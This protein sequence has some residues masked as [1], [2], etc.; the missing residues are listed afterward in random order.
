MLRMIIII[1]ALLAG[2]LLGPEISANKG[3]VLVSVDGYTSYETTIINAIFIALVIYFILIASEWIL[4]K[5][6]SMS[7]IS[8]GWF[9]LRKTKKAQK[10][11]FLGMVALCEGE[12]KQAQK[13]LAKSAA[14]SEAPALNYIAA[15]KAAHLQKEYSLRDDYLQR[16]SDSQKECNLAAGLTWVKLQ[17]DANQYENALARLQDV[18]INYPKN[19]HVARLYLDIYPTL[20]QW[21]KYLT[22]LQ[23][24]QKSLGLSDEEFQSC[25][26]NGY[27][28][29]F[30]Q[31]A[32]QG[33]ALQTWWDKKAPR[34]LCKE[35]TYQQFLLD[36]YIDAEQFKMAELFL[37]EKLHKQ[38]SLPLLTY[39]K[40]LEL[41]DFQPLIQML[42]KELKKD[43]ENALIHQALALLKVKENNSEDAIAHLK[44]SVQT[45]PDVNDFA[46]LAD[47]LEKN[48]QLAEANFYY[49][50]G[51][52]FARS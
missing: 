27:S 7:R 23:T 52:L 31:L 13:L 41:S 48:D 4:R 51:L 2:L 38:F 5:L 39:L 42:E 20:L 9:G 6:F 19:K 37:L 30:K 26:A 44:I 16:A 40:K 24:K 47:L 12:N 43:K 1:T 46:L 35:L 22:V 28:H 32:V 33:E 49:R 45:K 15:A 14:R 3:Y 10:N 8:R 50:E 25:L 34:W 21:D 11:S 36:A 17:I 29:Y 18:A